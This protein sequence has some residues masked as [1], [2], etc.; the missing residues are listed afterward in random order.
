MACR[1]GDWQ[2]AEQGRAVA[3]AGIPAAAKR[4]AGEAGCGQRWEQGRAAARPGEAGGGRSTGETR[5]RPE[6]GLIQF[7]GE[8]KK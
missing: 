3:I 7:R 2:C 8:K 5:W 4:Q 6:Q 1:A